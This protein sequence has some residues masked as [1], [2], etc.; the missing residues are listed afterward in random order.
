MDELREILHRRPI[1]IIR[2]GTGLFLLVLA[3]L[4]ALAFFIRVPLTSRIRL[5]IFRSAS[6]DY[7]G[8][9]ELPRQWISCICAGQTVRVKL[10]GYPPEMYGYLDG[11]FAPPAGTVTNTMVTDNAAGEKTVPV[12]IRFPAGLTTTRGQHLTCSDGLP[13]TTEIRLGEQRLLLRLWQEITIKP[14]LP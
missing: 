7:Y 4:L 14:R 11:K 9:L 6:D 3:A 13:A 10:A 1:W 5:L 12:L 8:R 2:W